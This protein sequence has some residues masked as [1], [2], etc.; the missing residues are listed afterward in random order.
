MHLPFPI[1]TYRQRLA[2]VRATLAE[3]GLDGLVVT[4]PDTINWLTGF[5][6]IGY[7]WPQALVLRTSGGDPQLVT[8]TTEGASAA[9]SS[10]LSDV[11]LYDI[12]T[13]TPTAEIAASVRDHDLADGTVGI[14][15]QAFTLVPAVWQAIQHELPGISWVDTSVAVADVRLVKEPEGSSTSARRQRWP[16]TRS[17][18]S[19]SRSGQA[20]SKTELAGDASMALGE[21]G[22]EYAAIPPMIV[23]GERTAL[24]H[25]G[26]SNRSIGRGDLVSVEGLRRGGGPLPRRRDALVLRGPDEPGGSRR[27]GVPRRGDQGGDREYAVPGTKAPVPDDRCNEVLNRLDLARR[28]CHRIG[29]S[30]GIAYPPGWLEPMTLAMGTI[31]CSNRACR[32]RSSP[33]SR[34]PTRASS[35]WVFPARRSRVWSA[36]PALVPP[37]D[38]HRRSSAAPR[39]SIQQ[40]GMMTNT[41]GTPAGGPGM[42]LGDRLS[43]RQFLGAVGAVAGGIGLAA[44]RSSA[45]SST[46]STATRPPR[47][48]AA[49]RSP[50][51]LSGGTAPTPWTRR[52]PTTTSTSPASAELY[53]SLVEYDENVVPRFLACWRTPCPPRMR[54]R[55]SGP[56]G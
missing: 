25:C 31:T 43:R 9:A 2:R 5:D 17:N 28:R 35:A 21:A 11:R 16:T 20:Y 51:A 38:R 55:R 29:C 10:W 13:Q 27:L 56:S 54:R 40:G 53:N 36:G 33:T 18:R 44:V 47:R 8:R 15:M 4:Q 3:H 23:S 1:E 46:A 41:P 7:L 52:T 34:W 6:T 49:A 24:V 48:S 30:L 14:D 19:C 12:A 45:S 42:S 22:S 37:R 32:S 50:A 39:T 26:A